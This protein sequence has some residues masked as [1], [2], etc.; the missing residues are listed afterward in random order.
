MGKSRGYLTYEE[1][2]DLLPPEISSPELLDLLMEALEQ[3][4]VKLVDNN[5]KGKGKETE[6]FL[7]EP[8][9]AA[10]EEEEEEEEE[11]SDDEGGKGNDP[12]RLYLRKMGSVS[13]LT[14]EGEVEIAK[15]IEEGELEILKVILS[16]PLGTNEIINIGDRLDKG[17]IKVKS[18]FRGLED[19]DTTYDEKEYTQKI[20]TLIGHVQSF[21]KKGQKHFDLL[22]RANLAP[23]TKRKNL[24]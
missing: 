4:D 18:I 6:E 21:K 7:K 8:T 12:V 20:Y 10:A 1:V 23:A 16:S 15:K 11:D 2:N 14:R 24:R 13:L 9:E 19:E 5:K 17:R 22:N 3:N